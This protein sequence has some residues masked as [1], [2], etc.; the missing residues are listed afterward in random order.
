MDVVSQRR[1][2]FFHFK[3]R[4]Y[5]MAHP[6]PGAA[7]AATSASVEVLSSDPIEF[8]RQQIFLLIEDYFSGIRAEEVM[9]HLNECFEDSLLLSSYEEG[10]R[11]RL[12]PGALIPERV[13]Q[14]VSTHIGLLR[15]LAALDRRWHTVELLT[16]RA[17]NNAA[18]ALPD[19][20]NADTDEG[21]I[22]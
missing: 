1:P 3:L 16:D 7:M 10:G 21:G 17:A 4:N 20:R 9:L 5:E 8:H 13:V 2:L 11:Y 12:P 15:F 6:Q 18:D 19:T 14:S 22:Q